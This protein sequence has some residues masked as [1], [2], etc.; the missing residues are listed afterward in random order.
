MMCHVNHTALAIV[1]AFPKFPSSLPPLLFDSL[2]SSLN[3]TSVKV[4]C[5]PAADAEEENED[6]RDDID[7]GATCSRTACDKTEARSVGCISR[8]SARAVI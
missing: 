2:L 6:D 3:S 8:M 4:L 1:P 7:F 5:A